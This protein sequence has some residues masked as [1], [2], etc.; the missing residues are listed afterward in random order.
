MTDKEK[1]RKEVEKL[2][3][4]LIHGACSS[5]IAMET[6][7]K[8]EAYNEVLAIL[9][10]IQEEPVRKVWHYANEHP[11]IEKPILL[12]KVNG[13][14]ELS[15]C[16]DE[17]FYPEI[18]EMWAYIED[19]LN[20]SNVEKTVKNLKEPV[21][22][23]YRERYKRIAQSEKFK[24][25]YEGMSVGEIMHVEGEEPVSEDLE[26]VSKNYALNNTP[27]DDCKDEIQESFKSGAKWQKQKD[28]STTEDLGEYIND[29]SKQFPEVS[30]AKLSRIAVR[31]AKWKEQ[32]MMAKA[33]DGYV[34]KDVEEGNGDFLLSADYL[35]KSM[36]LKDQQKVKVIVIKED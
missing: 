14:V 34:I 8:E 15:I 32:K 21:S 13:V 35:P 29:L 18:G 25:T 3:S 17:N 30:F 10:T 1:F 6:R 33:V 9:D 7:C 2:K 12:R 23:N 26:E 27:W 20:L 31:V 28:E 22:K 5:Q 16:H 11:E 24:K 4:S 19:L 36:G